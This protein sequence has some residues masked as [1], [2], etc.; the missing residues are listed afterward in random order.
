MTPRPLSQA[1]VIDTPLIQSEVAGYAGGSDSLAGLEDIDT[2]HQPVVRS[3]MATTQAFQPVSAGSPDGLSS[4][5]DLED[6]VTAHQPISQAGIANVASPQALLSTRPSSLPGL[7]NP[8]AVSRP[9][10]QTALSGFASP[11]TT[12]VLRLDS[13]PGITRT[14]EETRSESNTTASRPPVVIRGS[15]QPNRVRSMRPPQGRR[16]VISIVGVLLLLVITAGML[17]AVSPLGQNVRATFS[18]QP[19]GANVIQTTPNNMSLVAQ[20][21]ATAVVHQQNDGYDPTSNGGGAVVTGSPRP[22]PYG[23]CTYWANSRY[24]ALTGHWVTWLGNAYQWADGA[25]MAGWHVSTSPHV[26]SIIVLMP[27]VEGASGYGHVAVV[28]SANGNSV[29]TS[30]MNWYGNGGG[31]G[32]VSHYTFTAGS[33]VY[34]IWA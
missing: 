17:V 30:N 29:N 5:P 25:R 9:I 18:G 13:Q 33:G 11:G 7:D 27:G 3:E 24:H 32:I 1:G 14:L 4:S 8:N 6:I 31:F 12:R 15:N 10:S 22:W 28:E 2:A 34:F 21:T 26:P 19:G 20:A 23:V 16:H